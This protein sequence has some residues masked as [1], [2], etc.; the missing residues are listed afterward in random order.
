[1]PT[2]EQGVNRYLEQ[3]RGV[4]T[5]VE[6]LALFSDLCVA[7]PSR[8]FPQPSP[9][10]EV[11]G[12]YICGNLLIEYRRD[13]HGRWGDPNASL[14][15]SLA[16]THAQRPHAPLAA[17]ATNGLAFHVYKPDF[18]ESGHVVELHPADG[19]NLASPMMTPERA[20]QEI[21]GLLE[22]LLK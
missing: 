20:V 21:S 14:R 15:R 11:P 10:P 2:P 19:L 22:R 4:A 17:L 12:C 5:S 7:L 8:V 3:V 13:M 16:Q 1:M 6:W 18:D 9:M